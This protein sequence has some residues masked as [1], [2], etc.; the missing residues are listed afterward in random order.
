M[1]EAEH[2]RKGV[3]T[4]QVENFNVDTEESEIIEDFLYLGSNINKNYMCNQQIR[5]LR[6]RWVAVERRNYCRWHTKITTLTSSPIP[7]DH[8]LWWLNLYLAVFSFPRLA[9]GKQINFSR[10]SQVQIFLR[11]DFT[12]CPKCKG[13]STSHYTS[14]MTQLALVWIIVFSS[15]SR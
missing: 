8:L 6:L 12:T 3:T 7:N 4:R 1:I 11:K 2:R 14:F 13:K 10:K 5:C 15:D 9:T